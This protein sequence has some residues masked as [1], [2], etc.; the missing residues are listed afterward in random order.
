MSN[1]INLLV[2]KDSKALKDQEK[3]KVFRLIAG[4]FL[5]VLLLISLV[6]FLLNKNLSS[7][8][9]DAERESVLSDFLPFRE[10]EAKLIIINNRIDKISKVLSKRIDIPKFIN[11]IL[12]QAPNDVL[13]EGLEFKEGKI[14][15]S[16]LSGSLVLVDEVINNLVNMAKRKEIVKDL[17]LESLEATDE[18]GY[19]VT[20]L[21][22]I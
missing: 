17:S 10:K 18:E 6:I 15:I 5:V 14:S 1:N 9:L 4:G 21:I 20:L 13:L 19:R 11:T 7:T 3:L 8:T 22:G 16:I 12:G 2:K